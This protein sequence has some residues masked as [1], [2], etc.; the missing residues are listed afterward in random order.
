[1]AWKLGSSYYRQRGQPDSRAIRGRAMGHYPYVKDILEGKKA[2]WD[3]IINAQ[4]DEPRKMRD[5]PRP[6]RKETQE[7]AEKDQE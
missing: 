2:T 4:T 3:F 7:P 5:W 6:E 1:M